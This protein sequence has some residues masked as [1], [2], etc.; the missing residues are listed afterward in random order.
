MGRD[1]VKRRRAR[2]L[3]RRHPLVRGA[4]YALLVC[5]FLL[6][7]GAVLFTVYVADQ[8]SYDPHLFAMGTGGILSLACGVIAIVLLNNRRLRAERRMLE[9]RVEELAD[10]NWELKE[11]EER[12]RSFLEAQGDVIVRRDGAGRITYANDAFCRLADATREALLGSSLTLAVE[13]TSDSLL[14]PDGTRAYDQQMATAHGPRWIA[15]RE[16]VV[17]AGAGGQERQSVGRDVTDRVEAERALAEARDQAEAASRAKSRFLATVSHE[18]RTPLNGILGMSDLLLDT[19]LTPEQITYAKAAKTSADTLLALIEEVLDFSK[20]EAGKLDL[21]PRPFALAGLIE[22]MVEL[23][24]PRAQAKGLEIASY[25]DERLPEYVVGDAARLRQVLLNLAG[26]AV[27]FTE[28]GGVSVIVEPGAAADEITFVVQDTG[29]GISSAEQARVFLEFEQGD[30]GFAPHH[31]GTGLGLTI[32]RRIV[33]RMGGSIAVNSARGAGS[34]F[35]FTVALPAHGRAA[36]F[37]SPDLS[38]SAVLIVTSTQIEASLI[39]RRLRRWGAHTEI[40]APAQC[41]TASLSERRWQTILIDHTMGTEQACALA[42]LSASIERRLVLI[43]PADR[44]Q[45]PTLREAGFTGY[46]IKP[47]RA[48]SLAARL[49]RNDDVFDATPLTAVEAAEPS[50][51]LPTEGLS[52]LLAEDNEINALLTRALLQ[53]LG[54][55]PLVTGDGAKAFDAWAAARAAGQPFDLLLMD[56]HMPGVDGIEATARIRAAERQ[57][58]ISHTPILALTANAF[59]EDRE[60]CLAAGMDDFLVKPLDRERLAAA[61]AAISDRASLAA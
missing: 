17:R 27:K 49:T 44:E 6:V 21:D 13:E 24:A 11:S 47:V 14:L 35:R 39:G 61:L 4:R 53:K 54:H 1:P 5:C 16:V 42:K 57:E 3:F 28:R 30:R 45:L 7:S 43:A 15:W 9:Q 33:E 2:L 20:I 22:E 32:A 8:A 51:K 46:L 29:I 38:G 40:A 34:T 23:L 25:V 37:V 55:R 50:P 48:A 26:N 52:V 18:I 59:A 12:A 19:P 10:L 58:Q 41:T 60:A 36:S 31:N 56:V